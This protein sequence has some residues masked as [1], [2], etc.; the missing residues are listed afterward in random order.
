MIIGFN[1]KMGVGKSTA[2]RFLEDYYPNSTVHV[3]KFAQPLYD[4]QEYIYRRITPVYRRGPTFI[5]DRK[6]LQWLGTDW[7]RDTIMQN[8]WVEIWKDEVRQIQKENPNAVI[9]CDDVRFDNEGE[10]VKA[11]GGYVVA[12][13]RNDNAKHADGGVGIVGHAS[14]GGIDK[15]YLDFI[16]ENN[17]TVAEFRT[18]LFEVFKD[19]SCRTVESNVIGI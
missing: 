12:I 11:M 10:T 9:V 5:K 6:L 17:D 16:V 8:L 7:G 14:E 2:I 19:L 1:G 4:M 15:K 13:V 3:V 18:S